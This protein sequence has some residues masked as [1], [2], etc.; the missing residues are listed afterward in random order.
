MDLNWS[1]QREV[2]NK[3]VMDWR[4]KAITAMAS[5]AQLK[6]SIS[7]WLIPR[8]ETGFLHA[9]VTKNMCDV[10]LSTIIET[11]ARLG[12]MSTGC[13]INRQAFCLL[14]GI[15]DLWLRVNTIRAT[16]LMV[17]LNTSIC[18]CGKSTVARFCSFMKYG[19]H[20]IKRAVQE[21]EHKG[22]FN[23][24][25][26]NRL[27]STLQFL[28]Q[29]SFSITNKGQ[30]FSSAPERLVERIKMAISKSKTRKII[31]YTDGSTTPYLKNAN[32]G[33]SVVITDTNHKF[34]YEDGMAIRSDGNNFMAELA[35]AAC[36]I[37]ALP[38]DISATL[39]IDSKAAIG[40]ISKGVVSERR[41][42]RAAG[43]PWLNF[44]RRDIVLK[45]KQIKVE[46]VASHKGTSRPDQVGN[47]RAD[48]IAN[49]TRIKSEKGPPEDY[50]TLSEEPFILKFKENLIQ[51]DPR[52]YMKKWEK[53]KMVEIWREK[54]PKQALYI[55][56]HLVQI[57]RQAERVLEMGD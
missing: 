50:F 22:S 1:K 55:K 14:S 52:A 24:R 38:R 15:P 44:C 35:A 33:C 4:W 8:M 19:A 54:A 2:L 48:Q 7:E 25:A 13:S 11:L 39:R 41:R 36:V 6:A 56:K 57:L 3:C 34:I 29:N 31:I 40:A 49:L 28:K 47:E 27:T 18:L 16:E 26:G 20:E 23:C 21:F 51:G 37:K 42:I 9:N 32:S 43:R 30:S 12:E 17:N 10:W 53:D 45:H 5:P 46:H